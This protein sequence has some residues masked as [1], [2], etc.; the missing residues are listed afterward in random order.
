MAK[1]KPMTYKDAG[2][3][4]ER[5]DAIIE[6]LKKRLPHIGGFGG[7]FPMPRSQGDT[8]MLVS[9][10]DSVGTKVLVAIKADKH[11][12]VGIDV[13]AM[14][15]NDII[16]LGAKPLFFLDY[17]GAGVLEPGVIEDLVAGVMEGCRQAECQLIGGETAELAG[18]YD[19]GIYDL[20]GFAVGMVERKKMVEGKDIRAGDVIVGLGSSGIHSNGYTLARA[21]FFDRL[22]LKPDKKIKELNGTAAEALLTPTRI[23]VPIVMDLMKKY[24]VKGMANITGGGLPGNVNRVLPENC[25]AEIDTTSWERPAIFPYMQD[26]GPVEEAEMFRTFNMGVGYTIIT[27]KSEAPKIIRRAEKLGCP[28]WQIGKVVPGDGKVELM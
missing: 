13:V 16:V 11:D 15:V 9:G 3:D 4:L 7:A 23:Y 2:H 6:R 22:N 24:E 12:T 8:P 28:A 18:M 19:K 17:I 20:V 27:S 26:M 1:A 10:T 5:S 25:N 14:V 21:V